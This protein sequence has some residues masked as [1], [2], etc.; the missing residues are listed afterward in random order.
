MER[1]N[2]NKKGDVK[3]EMKVIFWHVAGLRNK[4]KRFLGFRE[5]IL[6]CGVNGNWEEGSMKEEEGRLPKEFTW[7]EQKAV[8]RGEQ[9]E[10]RKG[11]EWRKSNMKIEGIMLTECIS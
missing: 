5:G 11:I 7:I 8:G 2:G 4:D 9:K 10:V 1:K 6:C 3:R